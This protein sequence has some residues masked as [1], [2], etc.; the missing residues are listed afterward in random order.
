MI[1]KAIS[2]LVQWG[3]GLYSANPN[4]V[5]SPT[6]IAIIHTIILILKMTDIIIDACFRQERQPARHEV[7]A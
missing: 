2:A 6:V 5:V 7:N 1:G 3:M 4:T